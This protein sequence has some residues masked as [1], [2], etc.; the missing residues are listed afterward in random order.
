MSLSRL[1]I[2]KF[3]CTVR[4]KKGAFGRVAKALMK[5]L[6]GI[7]TLRGFRKLNLKDLRQLGRPKAKEIFSLR[8]APKMVKKIGGDKLKKFLKNPKK[9]MLAMAKGGLK[10]IVVFLGFEVISHLI[11][12]QIQKQGRPISD[13][14]RRGGTQMFSSPPY[15]LHGSSN[16]LTSSGG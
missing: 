7:R 9:M 8:A 6:R 1:F 15:S 2:P 5:K 14:K 3:F 16:F 12:K 13:I 4:N 11:S 10:S